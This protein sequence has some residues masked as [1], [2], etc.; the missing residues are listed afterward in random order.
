MRGTFSTNRVV[1]FNYIRHVFDLVNDADRTELGRDADLAI[2]DFAEAYIAQ[3][4]KM[5]DFATKLIIA[6]GRLNRAQSLAKPVKRTFNQFAP[7]IP[8]GNGRG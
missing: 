8:A 4:L 2:L 3:A 1:P 6:Q 5:S 7:L